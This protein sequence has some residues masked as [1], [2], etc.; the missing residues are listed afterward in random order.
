MSSYIVVL[1]VRY[2]WALKIQYDV[3]TLAVHILK[4]QW[5]KED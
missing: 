5:Y 4:L 3:L 1:Y 2:S